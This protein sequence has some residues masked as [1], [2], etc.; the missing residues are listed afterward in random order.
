MS[1]RATLPDL[2]AQALHE[3][4]AAVVVSPAVAAERAFRAR[5][6]RRLHL[7]R[8]AGIVT[9]VAAAL[10]IVVGGGLVLA[11]HN[12]TSQ[13]ARPATPVVT[14]ATRE[15]PP[16][17]ADATAHM[18]GN[19]AAVGDGLWFVMGDQLVTTD[20]AGR[21]VSSDSLDEGTDGEA[22]CCLREVDG[23][24]LVPTSAGYS[25]VDA[26]TRQVLATTASALPGPSAVMG[27]SVWLRTGLHELTRVDPRSGRVLR[28]LATAPSA[29]LVATT[30]GML[31][32]AAQDADTVT[33]VDPSTG[34]SGP[35]VHLPAAP[36]AIAAAGDLVY[37]A[38]ASGRLTV[39]AGQSGSVVR[40]WQ[41]AT[42]S[43][44]PL[45]RLT[46]AAGAMWWSPDAGTIVRLDLSDGDVRDAVTV[47]LDRR[48]DNAD[49]QR[50]GLYVTPA[51][52]WVPTRNDNDDYEFHRLPVD[53]T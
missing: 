23:V 52:I 35:A 25:H 39:L 41:A 43:V 30:D 24:V 28:T 48:W 29:D 1:S 46:S 8:V 12:R 15:L 47:S 45:P 9:A 40:R 14:V 3:Q 33:R 10:A 31:F 17:A 27:R 50:N 49:Q 42:E 51:G 20:G 21:E 36:R 22:L 18:I 38:D 53:L 2:V 7:R 5:R 11:D 26:E 4:A 32:V 16:S 13:P 34:T 37:V 44:G 19:G 6:G